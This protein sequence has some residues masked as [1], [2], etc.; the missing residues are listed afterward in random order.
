MTAALCAR[1]RVVA[2]P[3]LGPDGSTVAFVAA[4]GGRAGLVLVDVDGGPESVLTS[5][6]S[7]KPARTLGGGTFDWLPDGSGLVYA[8]VDGCLWLQPVD[9]SPPRRIVEHGPA[10]APCVS[11]DGSRVAY[12]V[13][14]R[15]VAVVP[16]HGGGWPV[17]LSSSADFCLDPSWSP[18]GSEVAWHEWDVPAMPWDQS[19]IVV[20]RSDGNG[21]VVVAAGG[22]GVA[23][24]QPR[25]SPDGSRLGFLSDESGW[26]NLWAAG[27][28]LDE[29]EQLV[30]HEQL[31]DE[32][33]EH[34]GPAWGA[35]QRSFA[36]SPDGHSVA[37][38]RNEQG[39]GSLRVV[40]LSTG[41][42]VELGRGIHG[43]LS[44]IGSTLVA[45][46]SGARTPPR[47]VAYSGEGLTSRRDLAHGPLAGV[48]AARLVEPEVVRWVAHD[49]VEVPG[50][51]YRP[52][53]TFI[54]SP[55]PLIAWIH[56]GPTGQLDAAFNSR[57]A[58]WVDRGWAVLVP[59]HRG[60]TGWGRS[61]TRALAARWG[62]LDAVDVIA[63]LRTAGARGWG[64]PDRLVAMGASAGGFTVLHVLA[65]APGLCAAGIDLYGVADLLQQDETTHRFEAHYLESLIGPLP[66]AADRYRDRSPINRAAT[67][68]DPLLILHGGDDPVVGVGQSRALADRLRAAGTP[69]ELHVYDGEGHGWG[70]P[71]TV[72][73]ELERTESF[74]RRH[75]LR[76][77]RRD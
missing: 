66:Q 38:C 65:G 37:Y 5:D 59:D 17:R 1:G 9:G 41:E 18:D 4:S 62:E 2:E 74:L 7:P 57:I 25:F 14:T 51:L 12:V 54:G 30:D 70:R 61:F 24:Q 43:G 75:V 67:I 36:W 40:D 73:D 47:V 72:I 45:V 21:D 68:R 39:L 13:D 10:G 44:W 3:R 71:E 16:V 27:R 58:Y 35:G 11:P 31:V 55:P 69:V 77:P 46:R 63:G 29:Q 34:G 15:H 52:P 19:R 64:D 23:V 49:G 42:A 48:G 26:M 22:E 56:G 28:R 6:P 60:S 50:R 53:A 20:R 76:H 33:H 32:E 8:G